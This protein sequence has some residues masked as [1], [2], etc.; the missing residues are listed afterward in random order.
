[1]ECMLTNG[2]F[3]WLALSGNEKYLVFVKDPVGPM[4]R[5]AFHFRY[6]NYRPEVFFTVGN[7]NNNYY[8][9]VSKSSFNI[10][11]TRRLTTSKQS[12]L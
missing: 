2:A 7:K 12:D 10:S 6:W 1:M 5:L 8:F 3:P 4:V 9:I 11:H